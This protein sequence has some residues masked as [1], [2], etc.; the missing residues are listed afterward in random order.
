[1]VR[2]RGEALPFAAA[3]FDTVYVTFPTP[4]ILAA[5]TLDSI[6]RVLPPGGRAVIVPEAHLTGRGL[7]ARLVNWLY[8]ITGQ[9]QQGEA[10][11]RLELPASWVE[12]I[13]VHGFFLEAIPVTL[14][15]SEV[16]VVIAHLALGAGKERGATA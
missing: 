13:Q 2:G 4:F 1:V 11:G 12:L 15:R 5:E 10:S 8:V 7:P 3:S 14:A 9:R 6:W 16:L